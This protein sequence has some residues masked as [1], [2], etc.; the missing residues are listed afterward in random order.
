MT[1]PIALLRAGLLGACLALLPCALTQLDLGGGS[2]AFAKNGGGNGAGHGNAGGN[3]NGKSASAGNAAGKATAPGQDPSK[4]HGASAIAKTDPMHPSNLG[5]LNGFL[6]ASPVALANA[7]PN[8]AIGAVAK[9]YRDLL[10]GYIG[11]TTP[12]DPNAPPDPNAPTLDD[13][14]AALAAAANKELSAEAVAAIND[15]LA[16][17]NPQ[18]PNLSGLSN[19]TDDPAV[20]TANQALAEDIATRANEIQG[21]EATQGL[22]QALKDL[23][24]SIF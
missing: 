16:E 1:R 22:G 23:V 6:N 19:P 14:A 21:E 17:Q 15:R 10:S 7:S 24:S 5:R 4:T 13:V 20:D 3:G 2:I 9:T 18:D 12:S 11:A 8:S